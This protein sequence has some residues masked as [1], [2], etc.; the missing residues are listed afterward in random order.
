MS[1][2]DPAPPD[3]PGATRLPPLPAPTGDGIYL[4]R[5]LSRLAFDERVLAMAE[6]ERLPL[7]ERVKFLAIFCSNLDEF[8]QVRVA[9]LKEQVESGINIVSPDGLGPREQ[10]QLVH[11]RVKELVRRT[12][13]VYHKSLLPTLAEHD[14][15]IVGLDALTDEQRRG[16]RRTFEREIFPVL[17][18]LAVDPAHPFPYISNLSLNLAVLLHDPSDRSLRF[19]RVK[20][21]SLFPRLMAVDDG[22]TFVALEDVIAEHLQL[23]FPG[24]EIASHSPFRVTRDADLELAEDGAEDLREAVASSLRR[25]QLSSPA[26][27]LE[28]DERT[29]DEVLSLLREELELDVSDTYFQPS[30]LG[31]RDLWALYDLPRPD[32]KEAAWRPRTPHVLSRSGEAQTGPG[33]PGWIFDVLRDGDVLV[34]HPYDSFATTV[35]EFLVQA[36]DDPNVLAIKHTL[37]RTSGPETSMFE[38]L[39]RAAGRGKQVVTLVELKARFDERANIEWAQILERA[40]VHVVYGLVG[41]KTHAKVTLVV[42]QEGHRIRRYCH[43]G[44]GNYHPGTARVYEDVGLFT[45][46]NDIGEDLSNLFNHLTGTSRAPV[47]RKLL[48]A[49]RTLRDGLADLIHREMEAPD[50][51]IVIKVN[52]LSDPDMIDELYDAS[53]AGVRIDLIVRGICCLRPGVPGLSEN[54]RVRSILGS[55]LEHSRIFRFGTPERGLVHLIGSADLMPR[56]LSRRVEAI[57]PVEDPAGQARLEEILELDLQEDVH[58]WSLEPDGQWTPV[59]TKRSI[60]AQQQLRALAIQRSD[61]VHRD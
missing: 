33:R 55:F 3:S 12:T 14:I 13:G 41:L 60:C 38:A 23:L 27:R 57:V 56:N 4:N 28:V 11:A 61:P 9:G 5:E 35:E 7:L 40:G 19:A 36:A 17:T 31:L 39:V 32:L 59:E 45:A 49:P 8:F 52:G 50:G 43:V 46:S 6:D 16:L 44:T 15:R 1:T 54:I 42:R 30:P 20:V 29:A 51:R 37:Y 18:P 53:R 22:S 24:M 34:H 47:Y 10:M 26:V 58:A 48:V 2:Q 21:P 25:Q